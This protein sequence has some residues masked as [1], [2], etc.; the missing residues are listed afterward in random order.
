MEHLTRLGLPEGM[1]AEVSRF[2]QTCDAA[3]FAPAPPAETVDLP[4][5][6]ADLILAVEVQTGSGVKE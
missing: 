1:L 5:K 4:S 6:A 2:Y 3:R